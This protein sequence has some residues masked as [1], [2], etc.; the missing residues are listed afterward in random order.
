[1]MPGAAWGTCERCRCCD[2]EPSSGACLGHCDE[3]GE[4]FEYDEIPLELISPRPAP[5]APPA[6]GDSRAEA[7][8]VGLLIGYAIGL[9]MA[10]ILTGPQ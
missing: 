2:V 4:H 6:R 7:L 8:G 5:P 3:S 10:V 1:M 9:I